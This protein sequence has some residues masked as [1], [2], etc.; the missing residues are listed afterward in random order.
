MC[1][2]DDRLFRQGT[3]ACR[4]Y[5]EHGCGSSTIW[6]AHHRKVGILAVDSSPAWIARRCVRA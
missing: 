6:V 4:D 3:A 5:G 2:G 1:D